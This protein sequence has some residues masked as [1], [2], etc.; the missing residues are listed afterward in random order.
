MA[1]GRAVPPHHL[2]FRPFPLH[3]PF[4]CPEDTPYVTAEPAS[5]NQTERVTKSVCLIGNG[6]RAGDDITLDVTSIDGRSPRGGSIE[7]PN[8]QCWR[9]VSSPDHL[10]PDN[11]HHRSP[12]ELDSGE[13]RVPGLRRESCRIDGAAASRVED[14]HVGRRTDL[15][16]PTG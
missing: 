13:R 12:A 10:P 6:N 16:S 4:S 3:L 8:V 9:S 2:R 7:I 15:Q 1:P 11:G 14:G 5:F